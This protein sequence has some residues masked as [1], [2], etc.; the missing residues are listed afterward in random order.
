MRLKFESEI[1]DL[2]WLQSIRS[3]ILLLFIL[4]AIIQGCQ[5]P[6]DSENAKGR[7][8][9]DA[10]SYETILP[11]KIRRVMGLSP[12]LTEILFSLLP[13]SSI[14]AVTPHCDFPN[15]KVNAKQVIGVMP[16]DIEAIL[17]IKPDLIFTEEGMTSIEDI[18][19]LRK[20]SIPVVVFSYRKVADI[21]NTM[22]SIRVWTGAGL[23]AKAMCDS[24][25]AKLDSLELASA[26]LPKEKRPQMLSITWFDPVFAYGAET[27]MSDKM[28]LA[29]G[30][31]VLAEKLE[32]PYPLLGREYIL[33]LD[34]DLIFG[35]SF[36][37][38]DSS[39]FALYP[40]LR[41]LKAY[42]NKK[43]FPL[44]DNLASRPGPR[45]LDGIYEL[46]SHL[47]K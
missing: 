35:G 24:L 47:R 7:I 45:F 36:G 42:K 22:D 15:E 14:I 34:P 33:K 4:T 30:Q 11:Q 41:R 16:L 1:R 40:E 38:M 13:D 39:F 32:K 2:D 18:M 20:M 44:D 10:T 43:I 37:K 5:N 6:S 26:R 27:W 8:I 21:L 9:K 12:A 31:N 17:K 28:R 25:R 29:G 3:K 19:R 23:E 46:S